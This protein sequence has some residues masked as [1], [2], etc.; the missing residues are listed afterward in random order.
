MILFILFAAPAS[1][2]NAGSSDLKA[3]ILMPGPVTE[4]HRKEEKNC[5]ACHSRFD[6]A[7][8]DVLCLECHKDVAADRSDKTG[9]HGRSARASRSSCKTCHGDHKGRD[10][11]IVSLDKE[12]FNH[13]DTDF[14]LQ[15]KHAVIRCESCHLDNTP[16]RE[17]AGDCFDCHRDQDPHRESLGKECGNCHE[18]HSWHKRKIFDHGATSFPLLGHHETLQCNACH[19]GEQ[20]RFDSTECVS[21]HRVRDVHLGKF[22]QRCDQ[23]HSQSEWRDLSFDHGAETDFELTGAHLGPSCQSCHFAGMVDDT[24]STSCHSCHK[25]SDI[26][27]GRHGE[28]CESCHSTS[29]WDEPRFDHDKETNWPLIGEHRDVSCLQCHRGSLDDA[30]QTD[31]MSCHHSDDVHQSKGLQDCAD[32]H[33]PTGWR[34][35]LNFDHELSTFPLEGM[36]AIAPCQSCHKSLEFHAADDNCEDC[37]VTDDA[38]DSALGQQCNSCHNPN[39]WSLWLFDHDNITDFT[40]AGA[41]TDLACASCHHGDGPKDVPGSCAGCHSAD[42]R[43]RG[44]FGKDCGRCHSSESF[45]DIQWQ[46]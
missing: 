31:C 39:A 23:C 6:K 18:S 11:D 2:L 38:H 1:K 17:T 36:H 33:R 14:M 7:A 30:L 24:P 16:Y 41:H 21:C 44:N 34:K 9:F 37:H 28:K 27:A 46:N 26:H 8:Q 35:T 22:G 5:D 45:G 10:Y 19:A 15:G 40:L 32:C 3:L 43:H 20:Y 42:D 12:L 13:D 4:A 29:H 25:S